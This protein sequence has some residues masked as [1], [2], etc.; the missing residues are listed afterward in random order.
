[1]TVHSLT[2]GKLPQQNMMNDVRLF[3]RLLVLSN[4]MHID[5]RQS[6]QLCPPHMGSKGKMKEEEKPV[7]TAKDLLET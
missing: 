2:C 3:S 7:V 6:I 1:M 5:K 4:S